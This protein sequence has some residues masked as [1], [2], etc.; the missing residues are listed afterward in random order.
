MIE[1][2]FQPDYVACHIQFVFFHHYT[3]N[4]NQGHDQVYIQGT[5]N[6]NAILEIK[7]YWNTISTTEKT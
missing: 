1:R 7:F 5:A 4:K 3:F 6:I 2:H